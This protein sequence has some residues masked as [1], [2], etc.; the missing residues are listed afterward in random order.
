MNL[1][2]QQ[3]QT[4]TDRLAVLRKYGLR[5]T[6]ARVAV[7]EALENTQTPLS[8]ADVAACLGDTVF[9]RATIF[10]NLVDM[11]EAGILSRIDVGDH[12]WRFE[13][14][15]LDAHSHFVCN[16]C[17]DVSCLPDLDLNAQASEVASKYKVGNISEVLLK[18]HCED[19]GDA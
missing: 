9:D 4:Q 2:K 7:L 12:I 18:G 15:N 10:R 19:C 11:A 5:G 1:I 8:H 16:D 13:M 3:K 14:R 17:G 6:Q